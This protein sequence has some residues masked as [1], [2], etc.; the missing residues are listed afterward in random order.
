MRTI[1]LLVVL[2]F[3]IHLHAQN[4]YINHKTINLSGQWNFQIDSSDRGVNENWITKS[5]TDKIQLPGSMLTNGKGNDVTATTAWTGGIWDSTWYKSPSFEKYS[6]P[7]NIKYPFWLQPLRHYVGVAWYQ[8]KINIPAGWNTGYSELFLERCHWETTLWVDGKEI[9]MQNTLGT[10]H[11]Y[12][13]SEMLTPGTHNLT[14][15]IDNRVKDIDPGIDAH[16]ISDNTQTNWNGIVGKMQLINRPA[17]YISDIQLYPDVKNKLVK[18]V[19]SIN[20]LSNK[21]T[22]YSI[23]LTAA[24]KN[25]KQHIK[26][27]NKKMELTNKTTIVDINYPMGNNFLL[28]DEFNPNVYSLKTTITGGNGRDEKSVDFGM[29]N[30][31]IKGKQFNVND[32]I[33]FL[34]GTLECAIFPKTGYPTVAVKE[35]ERIYKK[36]KEFGLNHVRFHSWCPPE[37][38]FIAADKLGIYLSVEA[39]TWSDHL[40]EGKPIDKFVYDESNRIVQEFGNHPSFCMLAYGNEARGKNVN[41]YLTKFVKYWQQ[42]DRR[43][44]YTSA[45]GFPE[46]EASDYTSTPRPRIQWWAAGLNSPINANAPS[47]N[48]DWAK[49]ISSNKP[50]VS[51]EIGQWCVY[52]DFKEM[53]K[54][55]GV[56]KPKNFEIFQDLLKEHGMANLADSF[57]LASGKLQVLCYKAD[58]EAALRTPN[59][60]GF[61]LL[62][63]HDFPGQGTALVGVLDPFWDEKPYVTAKEYR[64]FCNVTVPL[65]RMDKMIYKNNETFTAKA[66]ITN[67]GEA[68]IK[69]IIPEWTIAGSDGKILAKGKLN[70]KNITTGLQ[71]LGDINTPL[72]FV[73]KASQLT[74][75]IS[76]GKF[77]NN[78]HIWVYPVEAEPKN[79]FNTIK[80]VQVFDDAA[81]TYVENGGSLLLTIKKGSVNPEM[82]GNV[83]VGFSS[84]FWN[85]QWT[86]FKQAPFTLGILCNPKHPALSEFPTEYHSD[87]QWWDAMS[88]SNVFVLDS[89]SKNIQPI[90]RV[91]D[92]WFTAKPLGLIFECKIGKGKLLVSGIDLVSDS[93]KRLEA[94]QL[95]LSLEKYMLSNKFNPVTKVESATIEKLFLKNQNSN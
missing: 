65:L 77:K 83:P 7:G 61:Q 51:H 9:G 87:Y 6:Q 42:K 43:R 71:S 58:I 94:K 50:T 47:T 12:D 36:C 28:W 66:E 24:D 19:I 39:S 56:L 4:S 31:E 90:I 40:G 72:A 88:H 11:R 16:S 86:S 46:V 84:I 92:D 45:S 26:P 81:K 8:K 80:I 2:L 30:F 13:I 23:R 48:Y 59:F 34:R 69:N 89:I 33:I 93:V 78:W 57:L 70:N 44:V 14:L 52:P 64:Q 10:P 17:V 5:L 54:Y 79:N 49:Y 29:K 68:E 35:W 20:N 76:V 53:P 3:P 82:G 95:L 75:T 85:T 41:E 73:R 60:A 37:A 25:G 55:D 91:I 1:Q 38:A 18:A 62:D 67:F 27:L 22:N 21:N 74:L 15:R 63:L 32:R